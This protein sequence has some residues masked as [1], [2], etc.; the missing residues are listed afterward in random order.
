LKSKESK[1]VVSF[2]S[3]LTLQIQRSNSW[4]K[5]THSSSGCRTTP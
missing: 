5:K 1:L 2:G 3:T 4:S